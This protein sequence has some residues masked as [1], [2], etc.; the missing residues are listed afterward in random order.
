MQA[1]TVSGIKI[2]SLYSTELEV[3]SDQYF[4]NRKGTAITK[5]TAVHNITINAI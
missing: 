3:S 5:T 4:H 2:M 1:G